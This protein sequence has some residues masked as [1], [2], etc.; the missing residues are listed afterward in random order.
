MLYFIIHIN[1]FHWLTRVE[2]N[3][4]FYSIIVGQCY[5]ICLRSVSK[6]GPP[7][8]QM[9]KSTKCFSIS[10]LSTYFI[11]LSVWRD[12]ALVINKSA[13]SALCKTHLSQRTHTHTHTRP[14]DWEIMWREKSAWTVTLGRGQGEEGLGADGVYK[15]IVIDWIN[16]QQVILGF[17]QPPLPHTH[18][19]AVWRNTVR[20]AV[21]ASVIELSVRSHGGWTYSSGKAKTVTQLK[22]R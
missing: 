21:L 12:I 18:I 2:G 17:N 5:C 10:F 1:S 3:T 16:H 6:I 22:K 9:Q 8:P 15:V 11:F 7:S 4:S 20:L 13:W 14:G 19:H